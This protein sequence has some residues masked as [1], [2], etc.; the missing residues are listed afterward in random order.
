MQFSKKPGSCN[1]KAVYVTI[2]ACERAMKKLCS[3]FRRKHH[4][5]HPYHC[6]SCGGYHVSSMTRGEHEEKIFQHFG[7]APVC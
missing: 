1:G 6:N 5:V 7:R 2:G 3:R 4:V